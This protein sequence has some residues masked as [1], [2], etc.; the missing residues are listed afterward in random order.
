MRKIVTVLFLMTFSIGIYAQPTPAPELSPYSGQVTEMYKGFIILNTADAYLEDRL[1]S[2]TDGSV[3]TTFPAETVVITDNESTAENNPLVFVAG[4]DLDGG[5]LGLETDGTTYYTPSTGI[6]T[7][8]G[9]ALSGDLTVTGGVRSVPEVI[10]YTD[11]ITLTATEIVG[12]S[13]GDVGHADGAILV[14]APGTGYTLELVSAFLIYDYSTA[15]YTGGADDAV[16]QVGV[17]GTQ[18]AVTGAITGASLLEASGDAILGLGSTATELTY[19]D[20]GAISLFG[21]ALT[22]PGSAAGELRVH[23]TYRKH[24]LGL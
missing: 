1:D 15:A 2:L 9:V 17:T 13:A 11:T 5:N 3:I 10:E 21:T 18:V 4:G 6:I 20:N 23:I 8:T 19:A 7:A 14:A 22:Q 12:T 16:I 24:T